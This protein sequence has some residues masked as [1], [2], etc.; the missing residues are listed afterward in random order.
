MAKVDVA[1]L[2]THVYADWDFVTDEEKDEVNLIDD[3]FEERGS[4][5]PAEVMALKRLLAALK[6]RKNATK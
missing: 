1:G 4:V 2:I 3:K 5:S 6:S